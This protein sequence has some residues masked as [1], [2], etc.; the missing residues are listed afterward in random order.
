MDEIDRSNPHASSLPGFLGTMDST[1]SRVESVLLAAGV[2]MMA[3][4]TIAN[5]V[6][7]FVF[8]YSLF[9]TEEVNR[10]LIILITFAGISY[11]ARQGRH[12]RMSAIYDA[13]PSKA[14]KG[15]MVVIASTTAVVMLALCYFSV[16]YILKVATSG[17]VLPAL[18]VP[19]YWIFLWV[20]V[21][22]FMTGLQYAL[23]A[24]K[25]LVEPD[26]YLSTR[27]LEGY[28]NDEIEI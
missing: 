9:F 24:I 11:A 4:N 5:V 18:Q 27:V 14:R 23:T 10:I 16:G 22:F 7:R 15:F 3:F 20:P 12:I 2:L 13:L 6:G 26:I 1:I 19:V 17:R 25:N 21:G 28:D 8:Q